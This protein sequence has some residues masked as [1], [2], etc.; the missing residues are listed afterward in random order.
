MKKML[1]TFKTLLLLSSLVFTLSTKAQTLGFSITPQTST[2]CSTGNMVCILTNT[3]SG[4]GYYTYVLSSGGYLTG[5]TWSGNSCTVSCGFNTPGVYTVTALAYASNSSSVVLGSA[6]QTVLS[7]VSPVLSVSGP[8]LV[9]PNT[10]NTLTASGAVSYTWYAFTPSYT[11]ITGPSLTYSLA[12]N[13]SGFYNLIGVG[14]N[15]CSSSTSTVNLMI[16]SGVATISNPTVCAGGTTTLTASGGISYTWQPGNISGPVAVYSPTAGV[17]YSLITS[18]SLC[19]TTSTYY[20]AVAMPPVL[21]SLPN[22]PTVCAGW[23]VTLQAGGATTYTWMPGNLPNATVVVTPTANTC[24]T[25]TG[26]NGPNC[27]T[28]SVVCVTVNSGPNFT[29]S[30]PT[31]FC[32]GSTQVFS[33][34]GNGITYNWFATNNNSVTGTTATLNPSINSLTVTGM[35]TNGCTTST[36]FPITYI[37]SPN[38]TVS[39]NSAFTGSYVCEGSTYLFNASGANTYTWST[40]V[41]TSSIAVIAGSY[42]NPTSLGFTVSGTGTN[43]CVSQATMNLWQYTYTCSIVW[44][45]DANRDGVANNTDVLELGLQA[46]ATGVT[47]SGASTSWTGQ[48]VINWAGTGSTGWNKSHADCNGDGIIN[49]GDNA[50]ITSNFALTHAFKESQSTVA[51]GDIKLVPAQTMAYE[52]IWNKADIYL[53]DASNNMSQLY[54]L[55][56]DINYDQNMVQTDSVK[57]MYTNSFLSNGNQNITFQKPI[58]SNGK[59]YAASVRVDHTNISGNGK[60]GEFWYKVKSGL[61]ANSNLNL[62]IGNTQKVNASAAFGTLSVEA[63]IVLNISSNVTGLSANGNL[64]RIVSV[65]PNPVQDKLILRSDVSTPV[66]YQLV[67][68]TG[69]QILNGE[70]SI[71]A[72]LDLSSL[73]SGV[74]FIRFESGKNQFIQKIVVEK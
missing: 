42:A 26:S 33:V 24:Y 32:A 15:G 7:L 63:P 25:V 2:L 9:C 48:Y 71:N 51:N 21:N 50:A 12:P 3:V 45:G 10:N 72:T 64:D 74:Y 31:N 43:G 59:L 37:S 39:G 13:T 4:A 36:T 38:I 69:R 73:E 60:I 27:S 57:I 28:S 23:G 52:G 67:D 68:I 66:S 56:F 46:G 49:S 17:T 70:F 61:P 5:I 35:G 14:A 34:T 20:V 53:G 54:G 11:M 16:G 47:R 62:S 6:T 30:G 29:V 65:F 18:N 41:N 1:P 22:S 40:G 55:A 44:P 8:T 58:H 19:T